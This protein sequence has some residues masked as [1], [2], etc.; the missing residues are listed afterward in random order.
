MTAGGIP[1]V[2]VYVFG[3]LAEGNPHPWSDIDIAVVYEPF[4][5]DRLEEHATISHYRDT[6]DL[7]MDIVTLRKEDIG[8]RYSTIVREVNEHGIPA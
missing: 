4:G 7:P 2:Q 6:F 5:K 3:S 8:N 1:V